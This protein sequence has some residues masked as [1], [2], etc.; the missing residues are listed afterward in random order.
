MAIAAPGPLVRWPAVAGLPCRRR[1]GWDHTSIP[2]PGVGCFRWWEGSS[3]SWWLRRRRGEER[4]AEVSRWGR[5][6]SCLCGTGRPQWPG[7]RACWRRPWRCGRGLEA[8]RLGGSRCRCLC[9][10]DVVSLSST[11]GH[12]RLRH[13][14]APGGMRFSPLQPGSRPLIRDTAAPLARVSLPSVEDSI[15]GVAPC[16][17]VAHRPDRHQTTDLAVGGSNPSRRATITAGQRP[18]DRVAARCCGAGLRP[19]CDHVG[20]HSQPDCDHL[21]PQ[22]PV[23]TAFLLLSATVAAPARNRW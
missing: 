17:V 22:S 19:N 10:L 14:S 21:R 15:P 3:C 8:G 9:R 7:S 18:C 16:R 5:G 2:Y 4:A 20:G 23:P 11:S 6:R 12:A 13:G 1:R